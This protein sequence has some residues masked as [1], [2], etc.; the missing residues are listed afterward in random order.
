MKILKIIFPFIKKYP[1]LQ[2]KWWHRFAVVIYSISTIAFLAI[3]IF[4]SYLIIQ[5]RAFNITIKNNLRDF[6]KSSEESMIN[7]VPLFL[8]QNY[9]FGCLENNKITYVSDYTLEKKAF[10]NPKIENHLEDVADKLIKDQHPEILNSISYQRDRTELVDFLKKTLQEDTEK[11]Y[12]FI[13]ADINCYSGNIISYRRNFMFYL[14]GTICAL[15][16][17]YLFSLFSQ[18]TYFMG[19]IYIVYGKKSKTDA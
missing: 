4:V 18:I 14:E 19:L 3:A 7:T 15:I 9:K 10:C 6:S 2:E 13:G 8:K 1:F 12:C 5:E 17:T 16:L 11:R